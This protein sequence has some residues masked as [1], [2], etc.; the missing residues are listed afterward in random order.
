MGPDLAPPTSWPELDELL[1]QL[2]V[3]DAELA[4]EASEFDLQIKLL[5]ESKAAACEPFRK[6][7]LALVALILGFVEEHRE[8]FNGK[9]RSREL[10]NGTVGVRANPERVVYDRGT[11]YAIEVL[12]V[13]KPEVL[14]STD[15][16]PAAAAKKLDPVLLRQ[17][18]IRICQD[19]QAYAEPRETPAPDYPVAPA[20]GSRGA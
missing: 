18:S 16:L 15:T 12:R 17:A 4:H 9:K 10:T 1:G 14:V 6:R 7:R 11:E 19:E 2:R 5:Q 3:A 8:E 13:L 20:A